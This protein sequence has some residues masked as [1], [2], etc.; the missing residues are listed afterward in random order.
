MS[1]DPVILPEAHSH[2]V[3]AARCA[4]PSSSIARTAGLYIPRMTFFFQAEDGIRDYKVTGV[5]T[6][7]LPIS[8]LGEFIEAVE[9]QLSVLWAFVWGENRMNPDT[10][11]RII[12][13]MRII[14]FKS[15]KPR[16]TW[17]HFLL[18]THRIYMANRT[19]KP[20]A[21]DVVLA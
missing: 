12:A 9:V 16:L 11:K 19:N 8:A 15:P 7:A 2:D 6:C 10:T 17:W 18:K 14:P 3:P 1:T 21:I 20:R 13:R 5:Q 4:L